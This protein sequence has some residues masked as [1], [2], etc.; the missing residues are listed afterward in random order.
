MWGNAFPQNRG[1]FGAL[2]ATE[3]DKKWNRLQLSPGFSK[4][5]TLVFRLHCHSLYCGEL[6]SFIKQPVQLHTCSAVLKLL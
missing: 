3:P 2:F 5:K 6:V 1:R 4:N